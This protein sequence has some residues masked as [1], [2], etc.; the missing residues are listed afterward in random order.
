MQI[1]LIKDLP[2]KGHSGEIINVNDGYGKNFL[3]KNGIGRAVDSGVMA[4]VKAR[5]DSENFHKAEEIAAIKKTCK[6]LETECV[7]IAVKVGE[8]GKMFG[9]V[10]SQEISSALNA[11]GYK[12]DKKHFVFEPIK[13]IGIYKIKVKF[14][15]GL[16]SVFA[17]EVTNGNTNAK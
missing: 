12:I 9:S 3:I 5:K 6:E 1:Y 11:R 2:G 16:E 10:T 7:T 17:L 15:Y 4:Q 8:N 13:T 14:S